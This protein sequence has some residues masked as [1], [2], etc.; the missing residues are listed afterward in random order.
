MYILHDKDLF[1]QNYLEIR[2]LMA[3]YDFHYIYFLRFFLFFFLNFFFLI[4]S[5]YNVSELAV[6]NIR[7]ILLNAKITEETFEVVD[8]INL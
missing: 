4:S 6:R 5:S 2:K 1:R 8:F 7:H 3:V